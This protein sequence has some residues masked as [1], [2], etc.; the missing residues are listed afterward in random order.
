MEFLYGIFELEE[1][2]W[3]PP[4]VSRVEKLRPRRFQCF[5]QSYTEDGRSRA[6]NWLPWPPSK[7]FDPNQ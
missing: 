1:T 4:F 7:A 5:V 6:G 2:N 3:T